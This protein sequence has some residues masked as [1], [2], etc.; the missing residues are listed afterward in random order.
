MMMKLLLLLNVLLPSALSFGVVAP[1]TARSSTELYV[2]EKDDDFMRWARQ[3]RSASSD[4][5]VVELNRPLGLIL[6]QD[7]NGNVYVEK[8]APR[9]NA[10]RTG[11][12]R[13]LLCPCFENRLT[14]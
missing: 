6:N 13:T 3:S 10:A 1:A 2:Q 4:D 12:V 7:E 9:G 5:T 11:M 14:K 8:V